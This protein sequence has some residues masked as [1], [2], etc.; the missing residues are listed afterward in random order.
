MASVWHP[1]CASH[2]GTSLTWGDRNWG[3]WARRLG[4][5]ELRGCTGGCCMVLACAAPLLPNTPRLP[6]G[7][8]GEK[9]WA[10]R[11]VGG[12]QA[13]VKCCVSCYECRLLC[14]PPLPTCPQ[15]HLGECCPHGLQKTE[16]QPTKLPMALNHRSCK[17]VCFKVSTNKVKETMSTFQAL[18]AR[19]WLFSWYTENCLQSVTKEEWMSGD[20][21]WPKRRATLSN[22]KYSYYLKNPGIEPMG[23]FMWLT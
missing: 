1:S 4:W 16:N 13:E 8:C 14:F 20:H 17:T 7:I 10:I 12:R 22:G 18:A 5:E 15:P 9:E 19:T 21:H 3:T 6:L 23:K 11:E 2:L